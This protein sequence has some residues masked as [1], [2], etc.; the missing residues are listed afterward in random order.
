MPRKKERQA[1]CCR[2]A[3]GIAAAGGRV[4]AACA[5]S[6]LQYFILWPS[7]AGGGD[8][9]SPSRARARRLLVRAGHPAWP[10][11]AL[12]APYMVFFCPPL[13]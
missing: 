5:S 12:P 3:G 2:E 13:F 10:F 1:G 6:L 9:V 4:G 8:K 11:I 7:R